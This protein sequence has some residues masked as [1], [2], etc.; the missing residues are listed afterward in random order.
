MVGHPTVYGRGFLNFG[1][2]NDE[3]GDGPSI[4]QF[5]GNVGLLY[6]ISSAVGT[7]FSVK[8]QGD[9]WKAEGASESESGMTIRVGL[10]LTAFVF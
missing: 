7:D 1:T 2:L 8:V 4:T 10:G 9:S 3:H 5:G 6:M